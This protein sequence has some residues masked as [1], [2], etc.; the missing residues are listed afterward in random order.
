LYERV[1]WAEP[2]RRFAARIVEMLYSEATA[3]ALSAQS[4]GGRSKQEKWILQAEAVNEIHRWSAR[5]G[6]RSKRRMGGQTR[7]QPLLRYGA[8][9]SQSLRARSGATPGQR[10]LHGHQAG[11]LKAM[12]RVCAI[13]PA[14]DGDPE[15]GRIERWRER[16]QPG[17]PG[18]VNFAATFLRAVPGQSQ[19]ERVARIHRELGRAAGI[20]RAA[21][22]VNR[23]DRTP[24]ASRSLASTIRVTGA[25]G[26]TPGHR[27]GRSRTAA[28][29]RTG[30]IPTPSLDHYAEHQLARF[31]ADPGVSQ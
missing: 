23:D 21:L 16:C 27:T 14:E 13:S 20:N 18:P 12:V 7:S 15:D 30:L 11:H 4:L 28:Q 3:S 26:D 24:F 22:R 5:P 31:D 2:D 25:S 1:S 19:I 10:Q 6:R 17:R 9:F 29:S 8:G